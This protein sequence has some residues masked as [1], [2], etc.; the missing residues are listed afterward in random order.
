MSD[1]S[2]AG[3]VKADKL[4][5][6]WLTGRVTFAGAADPVAATGPLAPRGWAMTRTG[7]GIYRVT[8]TFAYPHL[9]A[10]NFCLF[11]N[12]AVA[13]FTF[14]KKVELSSAGVVD[15]HVLNTAGA[16]ADPASPLHADCS[17]LLK[18]TTVG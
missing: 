17:F 9:A 14:E 11:N 2:G 13:G 5:L 1:A 15:F 7:V 16:A 10:F 4:G 3:G 12:N 6:V 8:F 18:N